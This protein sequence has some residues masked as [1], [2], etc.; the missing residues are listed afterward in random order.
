MLDRR[1][2]P[3][4]EQRTKEANHGSP[5]CDQ[6]LRPHRPRRVPRRLRARAPTSSGSRSTTS[7]TPAML[8]HLLKYDTVYGPFPGTVE[9]ADGAHRRRRRRDRR[10]RARPIRPKLPW[11]EL[12]VDVVDRV[13]RALPHAGR[14]REASRG[15]REEGDRLRSRQG[16]G[17]HGRARRQLRRGLRPR[18][19]TTSSRTPRARRTASRPVAKVL[20]EGLGIRHGLMTTVHAY[21]GDQ[22]LLDAPHKDYRRARAAALQPRAHDHG[23]RK[24]DRARHPG[25]RRQAPG[26]RG[27]RPGPDGL[28][29]RPD[30]RGRAADDAWRRST[31][32]FARARR[33]RRARGH[34][35]L[36]RGAARLVRHRQ[37]AVLVDLRRAASRRSSTA[38]R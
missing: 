20:H 8:A 9:A 36:Q 37:V 11:A 3:T 10:V 29:R 32:S 13:D 16:A 21:T 4:F 23:R 27:S 18:A 31:R 24:G 38:R 5:S 12:G 28:A 6:R 7:P 35:A 34:P 19:R 26:L 33:S 15:R 30:D 22:R 14:R 2:W 25:A 1:H 17:R